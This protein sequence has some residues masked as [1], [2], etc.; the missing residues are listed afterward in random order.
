MSRETGR[1]EAFSDSVFAFSMTLLVMATEVPKTFFDLVGVLRGLVP[2]A[3]CFALLT[4]LWWTHHR[5]F[6]RY[7]STDAVMVALNAILLFMLVFF[8][9]PLKFLA[10]LVLGRF[11]GAPEFIRG[12]E[13]ALIPVL[14]A[15]DA[16]ALMVI[17]ACGYLA[18]SMIFWAMYGRALRLRTRLGLDELDVYDAA[19]EQ[20]ACLANA[21]IATASATVA[22]AG[23]PRGAAF[24]GFVY[25]LIGPAMFFVHYG[26]GR[27]R[28]VAE[29]AGAGL[30]GAEIRPSGSPPTSS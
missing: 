5:F 7:G 25:F 18:V 30:P 6:R 20:R 19:T 9:Y 10:D 4:W 21:A 28:P 14:R 16:P 23:G 11:F 12:P 26:R 1:I 15:A 22:A 8:V 29:S 3:A 24:S 17:Y 2:F 13:G 27:R